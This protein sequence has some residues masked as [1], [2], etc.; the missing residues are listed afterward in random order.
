MGFAV[1]SK[2]TMVN[3]GYAMGVSRL[4]GVFDVNEGVEARGGHDVVE[5]AAAGVVGSTDDE[6]VGTGGSDEGTELRTGDWLLVK[7]TP[8]KL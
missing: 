2:V 5:T 8:S 1:S 4:I 7:E 6:G 3:A